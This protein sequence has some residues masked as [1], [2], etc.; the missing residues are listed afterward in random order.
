MLGLGDRRV[1]L[2]GLLVAVGCNSS[3]SDASGRQSD[4]SVLTG[5]T[6]ANSASGGSLGALPGGDTGVFATGGLAAAGGSFTAAPPSEDSDLSVVRVQADADAG[7][8]L[9]EP[10]LAN[11]FVEASHD[12]F[13]TFA[14][15]VDTASYDT[16]RQFATVGSLPQPSTVRVEEFV[17]FFDYAYAP[18]AADAEHPF[19]IDLAMGPHPLGRATELL[20]VG[21]QAKVAPPEAKKPANLVFLVDVSGSMASADKLPLVKRLLMETVSVMDDGDT[22]AI[23]TYAGNARLALPPT[24]VSDSTTLLA[25]INALQSG[26]STNGAGGIQLAYEQAAAAEIE[27]GINHVLLCTD[28]DFNVGISDPTELANYISD[29]RDTGITMTAIGFGRSRSGDTLMEELS[30]HGDGIYAVVYDEDQA[31]EYV[32]ERLL[33]T[34]VRVAKDMKIQVEMNPDLVVAY[35][36]LGYENRA[37]ADMDFRNDKVDAGDIGSGHRVTALYEI[38]RAGQDIPMPEG[39]PMVLTGEAVEGER[40]IGSGELVRVKV[41]YKQPGATSADAAAEVASVLSPD[42]VAAAA[43]DLDGDHAWAAAVAGLAE[44]LRGS[45]FASPAELATIQALLDAHAGSD[46][47]RLELVQLLNAVASQIAP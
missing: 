44:I 18:P 40:E 14:A 38:V 43:E 32:N 1:L 8:A 31:I 17:N 33:S 47:E 5:G 45:P 21:I 25:A 41:R 39:A 10:A 6:V 37:I 26:G 15:D 19:A 29:K 24:P 2:A 4:V 20:R 46:G 16:F 42:D 3:A 36:L 11:P 9:P 13:S 22:I 30:N 35:R 27:G 12:P 28:G 34:L 7:V 23:V